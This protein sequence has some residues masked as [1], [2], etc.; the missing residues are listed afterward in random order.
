MSEA[1]DF[2]QPLSDNDSQKWKA[3]ERSLKLATQA[4]SLRDHSRRLRE[5]SRQIREESARITREKI[6]A[7]AQTASLD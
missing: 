2:T 5:S 6:L 1:L 3:I 7:Q 4:E